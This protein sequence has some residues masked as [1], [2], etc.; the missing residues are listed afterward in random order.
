M[1]VGAHSFLPLSHLQSRIGTA[2]LCYSVR[3]APLLSNRHPHPQSRRSRP[4]VKAASRFLRARLRSEG[5]RRER[6]GI[7]GVRR[8]SSPGGLSRIRGFLHATRPLDRLVRAVASSLAQAQ[9]RFSPRSGSALRLNLAGA[10]G[11]SRRS[12]LPYAA[13]HASL[14]AT[15]PQHLGSPPTSHYRSRSHASC[16]PPRCLTRDLIG[17]RDNVGLAA[18][19]SAPGPGRSSLGLPVAWLRQII[20]TL[21]P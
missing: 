10:P 1:P 4:L 5:V 20:S 12:P 21:P 3:D 17:P 8:G 7:A 11:E 19:L 15:G 9:G 16:S 14:R 18:R 6:P 2:S 13:L